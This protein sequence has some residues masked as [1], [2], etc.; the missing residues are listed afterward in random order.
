MKEIVAGIIA[1]VDAG[2]TTLS[3][4]LLYRAGDLRKLG[5][6][7][8]GNAF[9]DPDRLEKKRGITIFSHLAQLKMPNFNL[10]LLDTPGHLDFADQTEEVLSVLDYAIL[11]IS[12][13]D[14]LTAYT[15]TLWR[16]LERYQV[17]TFIF[18]N[19]IDE[20]HLSHSQFLKEMQKVLASS[21]IDFTQEDKNFYENIAT[22]NEKTLEDYLKKGK[23]SANQIRL[24]IK[25]RKIFPVYFGSAL[26]LNGVSKFITGLEKWTLPLSKQNKFAARIF[27]ISHDSKN[28]RLTWLR[29]LGGNLKAR[30]ELFSGE[31]INQIRI[32][33]GEKFTVVPE[34]KAGEIGTVTG[35][36]KTYPGQ[37][38]GVKDAPHAN[39]RPV[40]TSRLNP[41]DSDLH[42]CLKALQ[43]LNDE[44]PLLNLRWSEHL[45][46]L[47]VQIMGEVQLEVLA[48]LM[49]ERFNLNVSFDQGSILYKETITQPIEAVGHFEPL[50]HYAEAHFLL[51]PLKANSGLVF[52]NK[53][54]LEVLTKNWQ[55]QIMTALASKEHLG[56][57]IG[58]PITDLK[59]TLIGGRGNNVHTV[60]G[61]FR[62]ATYRGVRQGLMELKK[63][64]ACQLLEPWYRFRLT[65]KNK[66]VGRALNDIQKMK[67][68]F[69]P[70]VEENDLTVITGTAPVE[71]MR[72]YAN[73]L[74]SYS[75]GT[76]NLECVFAGY[77]PCHNAVDVIKQRAYDPLSDLDNTPNSVFCSRGAGH[78]VTWDKVPAAAQYPYRYPL[79]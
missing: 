53:C 17:P 57:L 37:G 46:E 27:K 54:S 2:K 69:D 32:Y 41:Q 58:A 15:R 3:E 33:N 12:I 51:T 31:K 62:E 56:V 61:D 9:L 59:I 35:L 67:G 16:L 43:I 13:T 11:V 73:E 75:H 14:G 65:I 21:C 71:Q 19:K 74:R 6:V 78:T 48:Q 10:T 5:R 68:K 52:E 25:K 45:R 42:A 70:P 23:L 7:D 24:L 60:G 50:R 30:T 4:A 8:K 36:N 18:V 26:K 64:G 34:L 29:I 79:N 40:M 63:R 49:R 22:S 38:I 39:L 1:H 72:G 47:R 44:D 20:N 77:Q 76:G 28:E 66:Q 55:H